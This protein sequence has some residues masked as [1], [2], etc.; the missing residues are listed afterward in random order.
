MYD[1]VK[2]LILVIATTQ[3]GQKDNAWETM[4]AYGRLHTIPSSRMPS[5]GN[6]GIGS[7]RKADY[8]KVMGEFK[9]ACA[10]LSRLNLIK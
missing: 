9:N 10:N 8:L 6:G 2:L 1:G 3:A 5:K 4:I 7:Y